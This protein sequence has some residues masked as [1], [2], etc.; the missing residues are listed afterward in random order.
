[1]NYYKSQKQ[2]TLKLEIMVAQHKCHWIVYFK[3]INFMVYEFY[4]SKKKKK[5]LVTISEDKVGKILAK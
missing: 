5:K 3:M 4:L 2:N 1:M